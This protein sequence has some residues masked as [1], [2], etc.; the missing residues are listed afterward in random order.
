ASPRQGLIGQ[1]VTFTVG[2]SPAPGAAVV[3]AAPTGVVVLSIDGRDLP[4]ASLVTAGTVATA[5]FRTSTLGIG[6][7]TVLARYVG[8]TAFSASASDPLAVA[9]TSPVPVVVPPVVVPPVVDRGPT[10]TSVLRFG[11]HRMPTTLVLTF[12]APLD[13]ARAVDQANYVIT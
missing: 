4:P 3:G 10:V 8:D 2:V 6:P 13:P 1:E 9:I 11:I 12:D 7:H 5:T